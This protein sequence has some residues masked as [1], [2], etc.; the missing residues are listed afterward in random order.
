VSATPGGVGT[1]LA[2]TQ[3]VDGAARLLR[4]ADLGE[5]LGT[6][7]AAGEAREL[8]A[9]VSEGRFYVAC[10]GQFKRGK[11]TLI[12][13]LIGTPIL[14]VGFIPVT[15]VP[16]VIRFGERE[17]ARVRGRDASWRE[18]AV[19]DLGEYVSEEHNPENAKGIA[20]VEVFVPSPLLASGMCLVDTPGLGSVFTGNTAATESFIPHI[21]A[22]LVVIGADPP[23]AGEELALVEAVGR[24]VEDLI[25]VINKADR[26]TDE[27]RAA[28]AD[29]TRQLLEERLQR[30]AGPV[31]EVSAA[32]RLEY[33][34]PDRDWGK[35]LAALGQLVEGSGRHLM[36]TACERGIE[37]LSEQL[38]A[39]IN[40]E[41]EAQNVARRHVLPWL[42]AEQLEAEKEY[43]QVARRFAQAGNE[44]LK[45]LADAGIH[46]I[47]RLPHALDPEAGFLVRS[48]FTFHDLVEIAQPASPLR[49]AADLVLGVSRAQRVIDADAR[50]FL[51][52][53]L[54]TNCTRVQS[55][56]LNRV[57]ES[58][59][60]LEVE[61]RKLLHEIRRVAEQALTHARAA[62]AEGAPAVQAARARLDR[63]ELEIRQ[64]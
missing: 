15:A 43:R 14:P 37:R 25:L 64:L 52:H 16:T 63:L 2:A 19:P 55:D 49:W 9:R 61:I 51:A 13:A 24:N 38:L 45:K 11:S 29:F 57:Q 7:R 6:N 42:Q 35:L 44:F 1:G 62:Q 46:E 8:A 54:E 39:I 50:R 12:N 26:T 23:L 30:P 3:D 58:R 32:E 40:A 10:L 4:L 28:A 21:D 59:S 31:F 33:R 5:E 41:R 60:R 18:I 53:L 48:R 47:A 56:I 17:K 27:E 36:R 34:G 22:A 20:G